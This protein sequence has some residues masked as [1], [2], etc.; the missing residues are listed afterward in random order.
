MQALKNK[1]HGIHGQVELKIKNWWMGVACDDGKTEANS[2][3]CDSNQKWNG[4]IIIMIIAGNAG[5]GKS[6]TARYMAG[7][8]LYF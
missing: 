3:H 8:N 2:W 5:T 7:K 1:L 4:V 6:I